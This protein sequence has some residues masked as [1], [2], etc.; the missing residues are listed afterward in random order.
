M[1]ILLHISFSSLFIVIFALVFSFPHVVT[2]TSLPSSWESGKVKINGQLGPGEWKRA[3]TGWSIPTGWIY[4][5]NNGRELYLWL[6]LVAD[7]SADRRFRKLSGD[8]VSLT[9]DVDRNRKIS[10]HVDVFYGMRRGSYKLGMQFYSSQGKTPFKPTG[11]LLAAGFGTFSSYL[12]NHRFWEIAIPLAELKASPGQ[13]VRLGIETHSTKPRF[14]VVY[15]KGFPTN[16]SKLIEIKLAKPQKRKRHR[17]KPPPPQSSGDGGVKRSINAKGNVV[18]TYPDG[19]VKEL[20]KCKFTSPDGKTCRTQKSQV[21]R[22]TMPPIPSK[23]SERAWLDEENK[24]L[25]TI[26]AKLVGGDQESIDFLIASEISD[27]FSVYEK[28]HNRRLLIEKMVPHAK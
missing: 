6:D 5:Q 11:A 4:A 25:L 15:P 20:L 7:Q 8:Y 12:P 26:I 9:F 16:F 10:P 27:G 24:G 13:T 14:N 22:V 19:T 3:H 28:I 17:P 18:I 21:S 1:R 23:P 2:A